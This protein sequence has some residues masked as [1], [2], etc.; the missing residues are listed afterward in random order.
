MRR[1]KKQICIDAYKKCIVSFLGGRT[2]RADIGHLGQ[3]DK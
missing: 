1:K 2:P 3:A